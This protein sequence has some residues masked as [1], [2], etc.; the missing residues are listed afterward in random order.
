MT[1]IKTPGQV[2]YESYITKNKG[3]SAVNGNVLPSWEGLSEE[4]QEQWNAA[5]LKFAVAREDIREILY[6]DRSPR[7]GA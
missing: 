1:V 2:A 6:E 5:A 7:E 3:V 4:K